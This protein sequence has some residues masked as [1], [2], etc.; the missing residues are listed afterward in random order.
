MVTRSDGGE[1]GLQLGGSGVD[2]GH[3]VSLGEGARLSRELRLHRRCRG[4]QG[5]QI[6]AQ[7][8]VARRDRGD[9]LF[10]F[11]TSSLQ[12]HDL[13]RQRLARRL[14][15]IDRHA[16]VNF[17]QAVLEMGTLLLQ[18][19]KQTLAHFAQVLVEIDADEVNLGD[20]RGHL[21]NRAALAR[22]T[23]LRHHLELVFQLAD[24]SVDVLHGRLAAKHLI[25]LGG[26]V[27]QLFL[28]GLQAID[29]GGLACG[30]FDFHLQRFKLLAQQSVG[31]VASAL[32]AVLFQCTHA[33]RQLIDLACRIGRDRQAKGV[34]GVVGAEN[35]QRSAGHTGHQMAEKAGRA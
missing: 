3:L 16:L 15:R 33:A 12:A 9:V 21:S 6:L 20:Q 2:R 25:D 30:L 13:V 5:R 35:R 24:P 27:E 18:I 1:I 32:L 8:R 28:L 34:G 23:R 29:N 7:L 10:Q 4:L 14:D 17:R 31:G 22:R 26:P 19:A 11:L